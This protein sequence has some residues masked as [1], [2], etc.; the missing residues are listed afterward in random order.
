MILVSTLRKLDS[1]D[2]KT[3]IISE[4][5]SLGQA[6]TMIESWCY[7]NNADYPGTEN[8]WKTEGNIRV[9]VRTRDNQYLNIFDIKEQ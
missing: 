2:R 9:Q 5:C 7:D 4:S 8:L 6:L 1:L 3:E